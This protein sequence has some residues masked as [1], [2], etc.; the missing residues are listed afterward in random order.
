[1]T[2]RTAPV[3]KRRLA[4]VS[5]AMLL[6]ALAGAPAL[7]QTPPTAAPKAAPKAVPK[8]APKAQPKQ[9]PAQAPAP[10]QQGA[11]GEP[12]L[13]FSPWTKLCTKGQ[14]QNAKQVCFTGR[15]GRIET[16]M[17]V[18]AAVLIEPEGETRKILRVTLPLGMSL[19]PGT[20]VII[21]QGQPITAPYAVCFTNGCM[22]DYEASGE[23]IDKMKKGQGL[24]VQGINGSGQP[25]T[26]Q[27]PLADFAK[28]HDGP[29]MDPKQFEAQQSK[30]QEELQRKGE[31]LRKKMESSS[32]QTPVH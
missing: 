10:T 11:G 31:E 6:T 14:E 25:I 30:M 32:Q 13:T 27:V 21:D 9:A 19:P 18:V 26:L 12:Q 16:G 23:L 8:Q 29:A 5:T 1:M 17:P 4:M 2:H 7:A 3:L 22:A 20:R 24:V 28:A 15:D